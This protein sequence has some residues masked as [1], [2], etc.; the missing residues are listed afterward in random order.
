VT[1]VVLQHIPNKE[2]KK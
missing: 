1:Q 2:T